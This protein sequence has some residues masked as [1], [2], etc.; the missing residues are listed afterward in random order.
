MQPITA[1]QL[2]KLVELT[3]GKV[4]RAQF[5]RRLNNPLVLIEFFQTGQVG[6]SVVEQLVIDMESTLSNIFGK[7]VKVADPPPEFI[8]ENLVK[9]AKM[10]FCPVYLP[11]E[12]ISQ[13]RELKDWIKLKD[14]FYQQIKEEKIKEDADSLYSGWYLADLTPGVDYNNG[15]QV[16][17]NDPLSAIITKLREEGK[18]GKYD[19]TPLGSRFSIIPKDEWP[20]VCKAVLQELGLD[21]KYVACRLE[22]AIESNAIG[23]LFD[24][25]RGKFN[26]WEWFSDV[27]D[28]SFRLFGGYRAYGG[29]ADVYFYW[30]D[31]RD[32][33]VAGRPLVSF[34]K[35]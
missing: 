34:A 7:K 33:L 18:I 28:G 14:W 31:R 17:P 6:L 11:N 24:E 21:S 23:N 1:A 26:I 13:D 15:I 12:R 9:W 8:E 16:F 2:G 27:F 22:R 19:K 25:N 30:A 3:A 5:Q 4:S 20:I 35:N 32:A 29:L 10:N